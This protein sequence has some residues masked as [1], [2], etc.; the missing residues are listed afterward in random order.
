MH[1]T[2]IIEK[3]ITL[4]NFVK[5]KAN[6][7]GITTN[8]KSAKPGMLFVAIKGQQFN[9]LAFLNE[10]LSKGINAVLIN[11]SIKKKINLKS[12]NILRSSNIRLSTSRIAKAFY[13]K[14]PKNITAITGTNG[15]TSIAHYLQYIW[16]KNNYKSATIGTL[17][18][19][20]E[21]VYKK[22]NLTTPDPIALHKELEILKLKKINYLALEASSHAIDQK[23]LD[24]LKIN[25]AIFTNLTR[26][27]L[28]YHSNM[29]NY[30]S[31]K[32]R[33][34]S[35]ILINSGLA[36]INTDKKYGK[37]IRE[38]CIKKNIKY[39]TYGFSRS[40]WQIQDI[41]RKSTFSIVKILY[42][43]KIH[44]FSCKL[45]ADY[46]IENLVAALAVANAQGISLKKILKEIVKITNPPGRL[47]I[48][49]DITNKKL[50][51]FID[52]AHSPKSLEKS[53]LELN[54]IKK[55]KSKLIVLF[56]CGGDRD[57]GKRKIMAK[58]ANKLAD[59]IFI[60]DDN[61]RNE[62]PSEIREQLTKFCQKAVNM[63]DRKKAIFKAVN[64]MKNED[65]LLIA[66]KGHE[67]YQ[68]VQG[69]KIPFN[70][71]EIAEDAL[72]RIA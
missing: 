1:L 18:I 4:E 25:Y 22:T 27:H 66:G 53:L 40:D 46:Q 12:I 72:R 23:R 60:T 38:I 32:K 28:D 34:F 36:I 19:K 5:K 51:I 35:K 65:I 64:C 33:L 68:E 43:N 24:S 9:G 20:Y 50:S 62:N 16:K 55:K 47:T 29:K 2:K 8:S 30:F 42:K 58:I 44:Q 17:G 6:I 45:F 21:K 57:K 37:L 13:P 39:I 54:K 69:K 70:D 31:A 49:K 11:S 56:G 63:G 67:K 61:P 26:D 3:E 10:A 14:Q 48:L 41:I 71:K 7:S 15:K 59:K 52:Y